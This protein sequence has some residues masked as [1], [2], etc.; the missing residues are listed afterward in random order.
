MLSLY[1]IYF[2]DKKPVCQII[3]IMIQSIFSCKRIFIRARAQL[4]IYVYHSR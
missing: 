3:Q 1:E 2:N 4:F